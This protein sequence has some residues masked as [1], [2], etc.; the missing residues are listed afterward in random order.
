MVSA[1]QL[2]AGIK[3]AVVNLDIREL[4]K[5][6]YGMQAGSARVLFPE[7]LPRGHFDFLFTM[8]SDAHEVLR[9]E[10]KTRFG[11]TAHRENREMDVLSLR[12]T[13]LKSWKRNISQKKDYT[14]QLPGEVTDSTIDDLIPFLESK[15]GKPV[16][17]QTGLAGRYNTDLKWNTA[18]GEAEKENIKQALFDQLGLELVPTNMSIEMLVVEKA[19]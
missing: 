13:D 6:A 4:L 3:D 16:V 18:S 2:M 14:P 7:D 9:N 19:K 10:L 1:Q 17:N 8:P 5:F 12:L 11:L 15:M